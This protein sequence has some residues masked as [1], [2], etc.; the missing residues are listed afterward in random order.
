MVCHGHPDLGGMNGVSARI[1]SMWCEQE[2]G[3][4]ACPCPLPVS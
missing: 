4:P 2:K 3:D 1:G